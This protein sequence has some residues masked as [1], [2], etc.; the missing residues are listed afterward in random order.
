MSG[1]AL[2]GPLLERGW[3][4]DPL[5]R[6]GIRRLLSRRL[7]EERR[8]PGSDS[9][10]FWRDRLRSAPLAL[11]PEVANEQHYEVPAAFFRLV[12][13]PWMKYSCGWW[14][15]SVR[16]LAEAE[17]AML[18]LTAHRA[19][20]ADGQRILDLGC[21]WGSFSLFAAERFPGCEIL[22]V[23]NSQSQG[24]TLRAEAARRGLRNV[25]HR[26]ANVAE[27]ELAPEP[28][29]D[30]IVSVEM[31][32]HFRNYEALLSKLARWLEPEGRLFVHVF[33]HHE[34]TYPFEDRGDDDWM[35][36][37]F[38]AGGL[39]PAADLLPRFDD[40]LTVEEDWAVSGDHYRRTA[41]AW[42][43]N[44]DARREDAMPILAATYGR[45]H[46]LRWLE[47]WRVFFMACAELFGTE[48]GREWRVHHYRLRP[49]N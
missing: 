29:F 43:A 36:R 44:L 11:V 24:E 42:L 28:R 46:A 6:F 38:F 35:A 3:L 41:E 48:G 5:V 8:S 26:V 4:P 25:R 14:G 37:H 17:R 30:R 9:A 27:L 16:T 31:F 21:G 45:E 22:A 32:E 18:E 2:A 12:L 1:F 13:G 23:S 39:M 49:R 19:G 40:D 20:I 47:R 15:E 10:A 33:C 7:L 34:L